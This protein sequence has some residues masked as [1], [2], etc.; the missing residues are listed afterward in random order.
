MNQPPQQHENRFDEVEQLVRA[1]GGY[2]DV[3]RDLRPRV[4][5]A[6]R[7]QNRRSPWRRMLVLFALPLA[8][9]GLVI[10]STSRQLSGKIE[11]SSTSNRLAA[12]ESQADPALYRGAFG[13]RLVDALLLLRS[14]QAEALGPAAN[15]AAGADSAEISAQ[16]ER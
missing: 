1:A 7:S 2:V 13:W 6:T 16:I 14:E 4:L 3:S 15:Q 5:E 10:S 8:I 9:F 11:A 12:L